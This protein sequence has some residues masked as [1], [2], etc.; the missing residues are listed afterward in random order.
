MG[1]TMGG[2]V[3][4][5]FLL[6]LCLATA[7]PL[8]DAEDIEER[9]EP[10]SNIV[11]M[12]RSSSPDCYHTEPVMAIKKRLMKKRNSGPGRLLRTHFSPQ[13]LMKKAFN[14]RRLMKKD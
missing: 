4:I 3:A 9:K 7:S 6:F 10:I 13:R 1:H 12:K 14:P 11:L 8:L 5:A 2:D